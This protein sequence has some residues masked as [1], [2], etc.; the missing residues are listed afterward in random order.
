ME[1]IGKLG[2]NDTTKIGELTSASK[3]VSVK[4]SYQCLH[5]INNKERLD[6]LKGSTKIQ[7]R[8]SIFKSQ[9]LIYHFQSNSDDN[10]RGMKIICNNK[11]FPSLNFI[12]GKASTCGSEGI[13]RHCDYQSDPKL[14]PFIVPIRI[15]TF[16]CHSFTTISSLYWDSKIKELVNQPRYGRVY[17]L[18]YSQILGC[19]NN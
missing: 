12:D 1:L 15:I 9:S 18:K 10:H 13:I 6:V 17:Y 5:I 4:F 8:E 16:S 11:T 7:K 2:S 3:D 19:C 14:G